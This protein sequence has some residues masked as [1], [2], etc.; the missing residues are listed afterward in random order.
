MRYHQWDLEKSRT[1]DGVTWT[2][3][4]RRNVAL[5]FGMVAP[6]NLTTNAQ[7]LALNYDASKVIGYD[8]WTRNVVSPFDGFTQSGSLW[9][10]P[11][12]TS[13][14]SI[15]MQKQFSCPTKVWCAVDDT[16]LGC[17]VIKVFIKAGKNAGQMCD[18]HVY[19]SGG[20]HIFSSQTAIGTFTENG[21]TC[22]LYP[23]AY[24]IALWLQRWGGYQVSN[25][26]N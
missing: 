17:D 6:E 18:I 22:S 15:T 24:D 7:L 23:I 20:H 12:G 11:S 25:L 5:L 3:S 19:S 8:P 14:D 26:S 16:S 4:A 21:T 10:L 13:L 2:K 9:V 1:I